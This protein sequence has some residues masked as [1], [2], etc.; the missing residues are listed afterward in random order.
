MSL[1]KKSRT[2]QYPLIAE[3]VFNYNDGVA[4]L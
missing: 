3:Y 2:A 1:I 4:N